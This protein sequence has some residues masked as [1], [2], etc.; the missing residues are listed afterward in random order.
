MDVVR[1]LRLSGAGWVGID[2]HTG[3]TGAPDTGKTVLKAEKV[4]KDDQLVGAGW[5]G[6]RFRC[7]IFIG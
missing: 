2:H 6:Y 4:H 5:S 3:R 1:L 7:A